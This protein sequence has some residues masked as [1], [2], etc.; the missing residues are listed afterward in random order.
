[1]ILYELD[2]KIKEHFDEI[3]ESP[4]EIKEVVD[5]A[6]LH[7]LMY[8]VTWIEHT[9]RILEFLKLSSEKSAI[10]NQYKLDAIKRIKK[11][12]KKLSK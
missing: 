3:V 4:E 11:E 2:N 1:M 9:S 7:V 6:P 12:L 8:L 5:N 10:L